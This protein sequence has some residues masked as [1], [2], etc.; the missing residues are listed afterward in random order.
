M[1]KNLA[2]FWKNS[3]AGK[4]AASRRRSAQ[5]DRDKDRETLADFYYRAQKKGIDENPSTPSSRIDRDYLNGISSWVNSTASRLNTY[6]NEA[7]KTGTI[8]GAGASLSGRRQDIDSLMATAQ[9]YMDYL[10]DN[11]DA[12]SVLGTVNYNRLSQSVQDTLADL[13]RFSRTEQE[14]NRGSMRAINQYL[15]TDEGQAQIEPYLQAQE[16]EEAAEE[17]ESKL[18]LA[19]QTER[20]RQAQYRQAELDEIAKHIDPMTE[21]GGREYD[22]WL[23]QSRQIEDD[24]ADM[25]AGITRATKENKLTRAAETARSD[26][27]FEEYVRRGANIQND[28]P[29]SGWLDTMGRALR[30]GSQIGNPVTYARSQAARD[31]IRNQ[32][33]TPWGSASRNAVGGVQ[34]MYDN[35]MT[36][37]WFMTEDEVATYNYLLAKDQEDGTDNAH[38][39][40]LDLNDQLT[41]RRGQTAIQDVDAWARGNPALASAS[42]V[43]ASP[44]NGLAFLE[45][46]INYLRGQNSTNA[47]SPVQLQ[48]RGATASRAAVAD[49]ARQQIAEATGQEWL[50]DSASFVYQTGM[51]VA[52]SLLN[53][54]IGAGLFGAGSAASA[55]SSTLMGGNAASSA[56][57]DAIDRGARDDQALAA[58]LWSG[59][60]ET[61]FE[62]FSIE[63][64]IGTASM[65]SKSGMVLNVLRQMGIEASEETATEIANVIS[66]GLIMGELSNYQQLVNDYMAQG[67]DESEAKNRAAA[68]LGLQVIEAGLGGALSG[69][70][71]GTAGTAISAGRTRSMASKAI[72]TNSVDLMIDQAL[73]LAP[74]SASYTLAQ[75]LRNGDMD[76]ASSGDVA[77]LVRAMAQEEALTPEIMERINTPVQE[78]AEAE[79]DAQTLSED[80]PLL[81]EA[82]AMVE[83]VAQ[84]QR[85]RT[86]RT[87]ASSAAVRSAPVASAISTTQQAPV[88]TQQTAPSQTA[89]TPRREASKSGGTKTTT[90]RKK[91]Q[92]AISDALERARTS[93]TQTEITSAHIPA[94][95][96]QTN[97]RIEI[98]G[99]DEVSPS[100]AVTLRADDG[101]VLAYSDVQ[102]ND[103]RVKQ[104]YD[105]VSAL[106]NTNAA[107]TFISSYDADSGLSVSEYASGFY[108]IYNAAIEGESFEA[109]VARSSKTVALSLAQQQAAYMAGQNIYNVA[110]ES[111][112]QEEAEAAAKKQQ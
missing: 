69:G 112:A 99:V 56:Y 14:A 45:S 66:D 55:L 105:S 71:M 75:Q 52:D 29:P 22:Q 21:L 12:E 2:D 89:Q 109:A 74:S 58:G 61:L 23:T 3:S 111:R 7:N 82:Q 50:G 106:R 104:L 38:Q 103:P 24:I 40:L 31:M 77:R 86:A 93:G 59:I 32:N 102:F 26:P 83:E 90:N 44:V 51:S 48:T 8:Y 94:V 4:A 110:Q 53:T 73:T 43:L 97:E 9:E 80:D 19:Q 28:A 108:P 65:A 60:F 67:M 57:Q 47:Y 1:A 81:R 34:T 41:E 42:S 107:R 20:L 46:G 100:G 84:E 30:G 87:E 70:V 92:K 17:A 79:T 88:T 49:E 13:M 11:E 101:S 62:K 5:V 96:A 64:F 68:D 63:N 33:E 95:D 25:R 6:A 16:E 91:A 18:S 98:A 39:Y 35:P 37:Y 27:E 36:L 76:S 72:R 54:A 85:A 15:A 10:Q 78:D